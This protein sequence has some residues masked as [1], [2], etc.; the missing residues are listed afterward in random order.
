ML[1]VKSVRNIELLTSNGITHIVNLISHQIENEFPNDFKYLN[2]N[3]R[4]RVGFNLLHAVLKVIDYVA[5]T[6]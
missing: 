2:L 1:D 5:K 6:S 3:M 4:D